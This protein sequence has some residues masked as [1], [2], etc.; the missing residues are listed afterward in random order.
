MGSLVLARLVALAHL[1]FVVFLVAGGPLA[2]RWRRLLP[3]HLAVV[4]ITVALNRTA[5][6]CPLTTLEKDLLRSSDVGAYR[7]GFVEHYLVDPVHPSGGSRTVTLV[8]I[9]IWLIPTVISYGLIVLTRSS[10][11][12][13]T[14]PGC[15]G[16]SSSPVSSPPPASSRASHRLLHRTA[17]RR[18]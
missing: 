1:G 16:S 18:G 3:V 14:M 8:L 17:A 15:S 13:A 6:D 11:S 9:A 2:L 10:R 12:H 4:A 5:T 7:R